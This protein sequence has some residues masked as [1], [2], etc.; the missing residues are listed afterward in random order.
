MWIPTSKQP[1]GIA[2][3][4]FFKGGWNPGGS[5]A[6]DGPPLSS[7][8]FGFGLGIFWNA[9]I[10]SDIGGLVAMSRLMM[11]V[12]WWCVCGGG[13]NELILVIEVGTRILRIFETN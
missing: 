6:D 4:G 5:G 9:A 12:L 2:S 7:R 3:P 13:S 1:L 11:Q 8:S 10:P